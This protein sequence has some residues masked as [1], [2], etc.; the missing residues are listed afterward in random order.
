MALYSVQRTTVPGPGEFVSALVIA[1]GTSLARKA[2]ADLNG[3][4]TDNLTVTR[5]PTSGVA[6]RVLDTELN[7]EPTLF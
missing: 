7:D 3:G 6:T 2:V 4:R 1:G 5:I